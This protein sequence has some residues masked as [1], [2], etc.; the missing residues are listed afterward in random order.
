METEPCC[1]EQR[2]CVSDPTEPQIADG[3]SELTESNSLTKLPCGPAEEGEELGKKEPSET[4][5]HAVESKSTE[6]KGSANCEQE[7]EKAECKIE[8]KLRKTN[9]WKM[10][11]FQDP[12]TEEDVV[13]R[14]SSAEIL[15]PEYAVEEWTSTPF[16]DLF[17]AEDW[18]NITEDG[19]LR[20][21]VL[22][23][24]D[25]QVPHSTWGQE[26]TV[27]MQ[28][29]LEDRTVV[30]KDCKLVFVIGEGDV[31][32][33][34]EECVMSMQKGE[35]T[36]LLAD[37]QYAYGLLGR[38]PEIPA[39]APLL[40]QLQLLDIRD[41]PDPLTLPITD[42]IR[43]G[44][45]KRERGNFHFQREEFSLAARAYCVALDVLTTRTK[46]GDDVGM[47]EEEEEVREYRIKCL[48]NLAAAQLKLEQFSEALHTSRDVL[49]LQPNNVKALFRTGKLLSDK[50]EYKEAMEVL[51]QALKLEPT[52]KAIHAELSKLVKRQ[53]GGQDTQQWRVKPA[54]VLGDDITP[55]LIPSKKKSSGISWKFILG[56]LVVA[57]GS[58]V[59]SMILTAR[60]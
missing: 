17:M 15:F 9:S 40:Y 42:R 5:S 20:K 52:T 4:E 6:I 47:K 53:S 19:M 16:E 14:D 48:N 57:L 60:N 43:I 50:G 55:F 8:K 2:D 54:K 11:R 30:E 10:V 24:G 37:S 58:L 56:A 33:A 21:K 25:I 35:I 45:Q 12:S 32:Q 3:I 46:D 23:P 41:K 34:L 36:L 22:E 49:T 44:N 29:V 28:G 59:T 13:E 1:E 39:W 7:R 51:K 31:I 38:E 18:E 27:K 26:V